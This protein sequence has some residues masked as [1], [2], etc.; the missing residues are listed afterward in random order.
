MPEMMWAALRATAKALGV[1]PGLEFR[2]LCRP[3]KAFRLWE[4]LSGLW[5]LSVAPCTSLQVSLQC[6]FGLSSLELVSNGLYLL[7]PLCSGK[8]PIGSSGN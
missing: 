3:E 2:A 7:C 5:H 1:L 6:P 8:S 4:G